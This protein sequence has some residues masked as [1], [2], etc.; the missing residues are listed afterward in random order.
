MV[1]DEHEPCTRGRSLHLLNSLTSFKFESKKTTLENIFTFEEAIDLC[2]KASGDLVHD[3]LKICIIL[4]QQE[5]QLRQRMLMNIA[6][7]T[8]YPTLGQFLLSCEQ[9]TH[10]ITTDLI[11]SGKDHGGQADMDVGR[12]KGKGKEKAQERTTKE[13]AKEKERAK[14]NKQE[15]EEIPMATR[16]AMEEEKVEAEDLDEEEEKA[17]ENPT[18]TTTTATTTKEKEALARTLAIIVE[19]P[20]TTNQP[21]GRNS[22]T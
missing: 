18:A 16:K 6:P 8:T 9:N 10:W 14:E 7:K 17:V 3:D 20:V 4:N 2:E 13:M 12:V 21:A 22:V 15:E 19:S 11:N 1:L 5:G